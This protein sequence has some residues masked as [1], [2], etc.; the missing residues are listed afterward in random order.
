MKVS[1]FIKGKPIL[2]REDDISLLN[3]E[4]GKGKFSIIDFFEEGI[5]EKEI[6]ETSKRILTFGA[7]SLG[8]KV[9]REV[10]L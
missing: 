9:P 10:Y 7:K 1:L 3:Q 4:F 8:R 2:V 6:I 5:S